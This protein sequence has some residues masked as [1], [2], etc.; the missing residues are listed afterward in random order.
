MLSDNLRQGHCWLLTIIHF[1]G[2]VI[3]LISTRANTKRF[4]NHAFA[5]PD[6]PVAAGTILVSNVPCLFLRTGKELVSFRI[7]GV[8]WN[9]HGVGDLR[10]PNCECIRVERTSNNDAE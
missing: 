2:I 6:I 10:A 8:L 1:V 5:T 3:A 4:T 7:E 9:R